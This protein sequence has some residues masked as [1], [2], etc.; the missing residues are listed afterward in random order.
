MQKLPQL[1]DCD[2]S[3]LWRDEDTCVSVEQ[4][5]EVECNLR[6]VI[7]EEH[8]LLFCFTGVLETSQSDSL[9]RT[10]LLPLHGVLLPADS[11]QNICSIKPSSFVVVHFP[12]AYLASIA[13]LGTNAGAWQTQSISNDQYLENAMTLLDK[14]IATRDHHSDDA[15]KNL[16]EYI[17][18]HVV[19]NY[20]TIKMAGD[21][22]P[23]R[24]EICQIMCALEYI[25]L[26]LTTDS[27]VGDI[28]SQTH[29]S[30]HRFLQTFKEVTGQSPQQYIISRRLD[31]ARRLL[32][33]QDLSLD[34]IAREAG[35][36]DQSHF[37][38][39]FRKHFGQTP[40]V[41]R[42]Q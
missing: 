8:A 35:F 10:K 33:R 16:T 24:A 22:E 34:Q 31:V 36:V 12:K 6:D 27:S 37:S 9:Q 41:F 18:I 3:S 11:Q 7:F 38:K 21:A 20:S 5:T 42:G 30:K 40:A 17:G 15:L 19:R 1:F 23:G 4:F 26:N 13:D 29:L 25:E 32:R 28:L 2:S 39:A 14:E